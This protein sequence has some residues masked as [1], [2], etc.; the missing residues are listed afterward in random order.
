MQPVRGQWS[1]RPLEAHAPCHPN[2]VDVA[3][4]HPVQNAEK[5]QLRCM[6]GLP[7]DCPILCTVGALEERKGVLRTLEALELLRCREVPFHYL[8]VGEG[9]HRSSIEQAI[10]RLGL[11]GCVTL[12]GVQGDPRPFYQVADAFVFLSRGEA[13]PLAPLEAMATGLPIIAARHPPLDEFLP[14]KGT[15]FVDDAA[16]DEV[17]DSLVALLGAPERMRAMGVFNR[18]YAA[19]HYAWDSVVDQYDA[20]VRSLLPRTAYQGQHA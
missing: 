5:A 3:Y 11:A 12:A 14:I 18:A 17:S 4:F 19:E 9:A 8:V 7:D 20:L 16:P 15:V 2:G 6:L 13:A 10:V 1:A